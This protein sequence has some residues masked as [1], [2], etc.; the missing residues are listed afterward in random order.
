VS[1]WFKCR[2]QVHVNDA[3][4]ELFGYARDEIIGHTSVE[5]G[6][7]VDPKEYVWLLAELEIQ[8][9]VRQ[10][11]ATYRHKSDCIGQLLIAV[12]E[13][14]LGGRRCAMELYS[15]I[16]A[17]KQ[18]ETLLTNLN[19]H[20]ERQVAQRTTELTKYAIRKGLTSLT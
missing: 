16:T 19:D 6:L 5:L 15:D 11:E 17:R 20:L 4:V 1:P 13:I 18:A 2:F 14:D 12:E 8:G 10:F 7:W 9:R 3:F